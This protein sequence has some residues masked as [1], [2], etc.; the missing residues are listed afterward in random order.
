MTFNSLFDSIG[1]S[2]NKGWPTK[3]SWLS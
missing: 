3:S 1:E 2:K